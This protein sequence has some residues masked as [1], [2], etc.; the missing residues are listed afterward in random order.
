MLCFSAK[1]PLRGFWV[2]AVRR[3]RLT[4]GKPNYIGPPLPLSNKI[5]PITPNALMY[6]TAY[7][8]EWLSAMVYQCMHQVI[9]G[10][11]HA[12]IYKACIQWIAK[13]LQEGKGRNWETCSLWWF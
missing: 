13:V 5:Y 1:I 8:V 2:V 12:P 7:F 10:S 6:K 3:G 11:V 4:D 9:W